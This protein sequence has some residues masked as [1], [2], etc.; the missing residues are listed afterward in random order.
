MLPLY[1]PQF[2]TRLNLTLTYSYFDYFEGVTLARLLYTLKV[3]LKF[4]VDGL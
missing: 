3:H 4:I 1:N 2:K